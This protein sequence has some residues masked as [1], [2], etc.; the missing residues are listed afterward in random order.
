MSKTHDFKGYLSAYHSEVSG[1]K[2]LLSLTFPNGRKSRILIDCG[3]FQEVKYRYLNYV[4]DFDPSKID[5]ILITHNHLDHTGMLPKMF[6]Y[7]FR[8]KI[9]MSKITLDLLPRFLM[10]SASKQERNAKE[11][12]QIY[13]GEEWRFKALYNE[14]DVKKTLNLCIGLDYQETVEI[15]PGVEVT[16]FINGHILGASMILVQCYYPG[17][18]PLCYL[19]TGDY[20]LSNPFFEVP[21]LPNWLR[22]TELIVAHEATY[23]ATRA[24]DIDVCFRKN[25]LEAFSK[26]QDILIGAFAQGRMQDILYDFK[27]FQI[28]GIIPDCYDICVDGFLGIQTTYKY[29]RILRDFNPEASDFIPYGIVQVD[30]KDRKSILKSERHIIVITT[31]GMLSKGPARV[32]VPAFLEHENALIHLTGYAA[33]DTLARLL[34]DTRDS[35]VIEI[36][37]HLYTRK[38][39]IKTTMEK[40]AHPTQDEILK[41]IGKF[42]N[43]SFLAINHGNKDVKNGLKA[44]IEENCSNVKQ[45]GILNRETMYCFTRSKKKGDRAG[46]IIVREL[47]AKFDDGLVTTSQSKY[48]KNNGNQKAKQNRKGA[49]RQR[50]KAKK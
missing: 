23:G 27:K 13:P 17:L 12:A 28:E 32:Y 16:F 49:N 43:I 22:K 9:Y 41:F 18:K 25:M 11:V 50:G 29:Q 46:D 4:N 1:S 31:S 6:R 2:L 48:K 8:N 26:K 30:P 21:E 35:D 36:D 34:L 39:E 10:D 42:E 14:D 20:K 45:V 19:F 44:V 7:G 38:A 40:S 3:S 15:L 33:E 24:K 5:A 47:P 37:G